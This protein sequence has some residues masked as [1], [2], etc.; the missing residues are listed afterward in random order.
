MVEN[1]IK[2]DIQSKI[3]ALRVKAEEF[4]SAG[5]WGRAENCR[6]LIAYLE[7]FLGGDRNENRTEVPCRK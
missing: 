1:A 5:D 6:V 7:D 3:K 4:K 2:I